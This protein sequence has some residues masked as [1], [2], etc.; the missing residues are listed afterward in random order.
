MGL[1]SVSMEP[2]IRLDGGVFMEPPCVDTTTGQTLCKYLL[3]LLMRTW[4]GTGLQNEKYA[5]QP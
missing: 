5:W 2:C 4:M 1:D 3:M